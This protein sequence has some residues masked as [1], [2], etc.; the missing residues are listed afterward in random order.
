[1]YQIAPLIIALAEGN[2]AK[3][4]IAGRSSSWVLDVV[5]GIR[6]SA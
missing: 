6:G 4:P 5:R 1:V 2:G 3:R